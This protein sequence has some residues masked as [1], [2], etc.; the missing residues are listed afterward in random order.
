MS[1]LPKLLAVYLLLLLL[2]LIVQGAL[3]I[4]RSKS[5]KVRILRTLMEMEFN[6][7]DQPETLPPM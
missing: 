2:L 6:V 7:K 3:P 1:A 4:R 5:S